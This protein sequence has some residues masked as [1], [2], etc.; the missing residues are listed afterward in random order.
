MLFFYQKVMSSLTCA[1]LQG[2][3]NSCSPIT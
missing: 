1:A 3:N 2:G